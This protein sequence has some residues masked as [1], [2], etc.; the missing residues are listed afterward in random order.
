MNKIF[1]S[2]F[3]ISIILFS[4]IIKLNANDDTYINS[5]NI[6][7]NEKE[8]IVELAKNSKININNISILIDKGIIDYNKN[9]FEVFGNFYLY[10]ELTIL[11]GQNLKGNTNLNNFTANNA[12]YIYNDDL[13]IDA[14]NLNR[15]NNLVYFYNNFVTPCELEGYF[16]CPTWS[17]RIDKTEYD[18][19]KDQFTHFDSFLQIADYKVFY[20]PYFSHYGAKAPRKKGFLTPTVEF[21]IGGDQGIIT[22]Y[23]LPVNIN[24]DILLKPK[25]F[26]NENFEFLETYQLNTLIQNKSS[27]GETLVEIDNIKYQDNDNINTSLKIE[28]KQVLNPRS[29]ISASGLF[30]NSIS[31]TRSINEEPITF[32]DLYIKIE[33]YDFFIKNDYL[34]AELS[35]VESFESTDLNSVPISP[36]FNYLNFYTLEDYFLINDLDFTILKRNNSSS[37][38]PSESFKINLSNE[39]KKYSHTDNLFISN[40]LLLNNNV[41]EYYFIDDNSLNHNSIKSNLVLSS[42]INY[43]NKSFITPR[44]KLLF[45][46]SLENSDKNINEDSKSITFNYQNQFSE[47]RFF[48]NDLFDTSPRLVYGIEST[49]KYNQN[50]IDI[51]FNQSFEVNSNSNYS[52]ILNQ[53]SKFSDYAIEGKL[54]SNKISL[55][56]DL[57]LDQNNFSKKEMNYS[58]NLKKPI[59]LFLNYNETK[60]EAFKDLSNDT[61]SIDLGISKKINKNVNLSYRSSLDVK[62]NYNPYES[63][64]KISLFDEC[65]QLDINYSNIRFN[66]N[67][68]TQPE[69]IISITFSMDYLGFF[70]Y[71]Q[72][73]NLFFSEPGNLNYG[74]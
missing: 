70:G 48:G 39:L 33:N 29:I 14:K 30:T 52:N 27:G 63:S 20:L 1:I 26:L 42:D 59:N 71:E 60:I 44:V 5:T 4:Q 16:N 67:Y 13:K 10:E 22:P 58:I 56:M 61:Q 37:T 43:N 18:I 35:S 49:H 47:N 11:S 50:L 17:L 57:R 40:K 74:L 55:K 62:N 15:N 66:D 23:Y 54:N 21:T 2:I 38:N 46:L 73:T 36:S 34:K 31:T 41:S 19:E 72:S 25:I 68:N 6:T 12:S 53:N 32:E 51:N 9:E 24:T 45:P 7:Y 65:S 64:L 69:E 28:T 8:N 3:S